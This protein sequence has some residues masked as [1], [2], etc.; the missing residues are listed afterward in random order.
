[1]SAL[2]E[3]PQQEVRSV[4]DGFPRGAC[5][6][7]SYALGVVLDDLGLW[8]WRRVTC[9]DPER[10]SEAHTWLELRDSRGRVVLVVDATVH[11]FAELASGPYIGPGPGPAQRR[12]SR[13]AKDYAS[14]S[15]PSF[16]I[17]VTELEALRVAREA[18]IG[19]AEA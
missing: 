2:A 8:S 11:Q 9:T 17:G 16:E 15:L 13:P 14:T 6:A 1:M 10:W 19:E 18:L 4:L 3:R 5:D 12:F 7:A